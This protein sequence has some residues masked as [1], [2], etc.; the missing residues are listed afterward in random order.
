M[1]ATGLRCVECNAV[2]PLEPKY[3]VCPTCGLEKVKGISVFRGITE[4]QYDYEAL[5]TSVSKELFASRPFNLLRYRELLGFDGENVI[6]LGEGGTSLIKCGKLAEKFGLNN[7]WLKN[8]TQNP[9]HSFKDRESVLAINKALEFRKKYVSCVSS[10]NAAASLAAYAARAGLGCFVFMPATTSKGKIS[11][12]TLYGAVTL[13]MDG[14]YEEIFELY[15]ES[16]EGLDI[17]E[18]SPGYNRFRMEGDKTLAYEI[19][20]QLGWKAPEWVIDNVGNGTH[21]YAIWKGFNELRNLGLIANVPRMV[22]TAPQAGAPIVAG[23]KQGTALPLASSSKSIAEGLVGRW[24]YDTPIALKALKESSGHAEPVSEL[25][26]LQAMEWLA[27]LEGVFAEPSAV[28]CIAGLSKMIKAGMIDKEEEVVCI[29]TGSGLKDPESG[30]RISEK[31]TL[32]PASVHEIRTT[33]QKH[34]SH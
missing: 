18:S 9:T 11:Q 19:C 4:V 17:F 15:I 29:I 23:F 21:L 2:F 16:L 33:L 3:Y 20:E 25:E 26:I 1:Y 24:G 5:R 7:L 14:I 8:E 28:T 12:C 13:L 27:R 6:T 30:K 10:G 22:A 32:V 34:L 31:P